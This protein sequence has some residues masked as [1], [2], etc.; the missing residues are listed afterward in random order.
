MYNATCDILSGNR[1]NEIRLN[2]F[3]Q[4]VKFKNVKEIIIFILFI[5]HF[6]CYKKPKIYIRIGFDSSININAN[7]LLKNIRLLF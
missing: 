5:T 3:Y 4:F 7:L 2:E 1:A 6:T